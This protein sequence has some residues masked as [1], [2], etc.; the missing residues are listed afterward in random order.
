MVVRSVLLSCFSMCLTLFIIIGSGQGGYCLSVQ[1]RIV[2]SVDEYK[3]IEPSSYAIKSLTT[4]NSYI[5]Y[6]CSFNFHRAKYNINPNYIRALICTESAGNPKAVS[7][8]KALGLTQILYETGQRWAGELA[9]THYD[10]R[11]I[12]EKVLSNLKPEDL[13]DPALNI[14]LACYGTDKFNALFGGKDFVS[15]AASWN[16]GHHRVIK[17]KG[18]PPYKETIRFLGKVNGY[19]LFF[20]RKGCSSRL[21][22]R[23]FPKRDVLRRQLALDGG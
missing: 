2:Q 18:C 8:D 11:Y 14:L 19:M 6:F 12:D 13:F 5:L 9:E 7:V 22:I 21:K 3:V 17:H 10:F 1:K 20:M 23:N 16:A 4:Y 15:I